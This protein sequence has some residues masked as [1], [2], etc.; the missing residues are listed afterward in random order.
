MCGMIYRW[1]PGARQPKPPSKIKNILIIWTAK[2]Y[3]TSLVFDKEFMSKI[4]YLSN[5]VKEWII[6]VWHTQR[7]WL[8]G[9]HTFINQSFTMEIRLW[10]KFTLVH[11]AGKRLLPT[12]HNHTTG[13]ITAR[14][15]RSVYFTYAQTQIVL[16]WKQSGLA[17]TIAPVFVK[18]ATM[19]NYIVNI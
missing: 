18:T 15:A 11:A 5:K 13:H 16:N 12:R 3:K 1:C 2:E 6:F 8:Q 10:K 19:K 7:S 9:N 14:N 17:K 4:K